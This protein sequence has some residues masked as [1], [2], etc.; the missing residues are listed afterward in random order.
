MQ[1]NLI[2]IKGPFTLA[3]YPCITYV[4]FIEFLGNAT[5]TYDSALLGNSIKQTMAAHGYAV[6]K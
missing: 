4:W 5:Q 6:S 3:A 2:T 1:I